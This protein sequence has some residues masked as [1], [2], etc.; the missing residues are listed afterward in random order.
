MLMLLGFVPDAGCDAGTSYPAYGVR[1]LLMLLGFV[2]DAG[3]GAGA[4]YL[5]CGLCNL[6]MLLGL[7]LMPDAVLT[8]LIRPAGCAIC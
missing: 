7:Y 2:P 6:L 5:A 8:H 1:N 4:S 3:C